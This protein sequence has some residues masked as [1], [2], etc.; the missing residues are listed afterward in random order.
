MSAEKNDILN[1]LFWSNLAAFTAH[2]LDESMMGGGFVTFIQTHFWAGFTSADFFTANA[3]WLSLITVSC[4]LYDGFGKRLAAIPMGFVWERCF[5]ALFHLGSTLYLRE[6]SP[7]L[8]TGVL[9]LIIFY[10][11]CRYALPREHLSLPAFISSGIAA[12]LFEMVFVSS[13][14]WA[15]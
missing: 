7:G 10:L 12:A 15:H 13:M 9:F 1:F 2:L 14:W 6:Y 3:V 4:L 11:I 5:N 8:V